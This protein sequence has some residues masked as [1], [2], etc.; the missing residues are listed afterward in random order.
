MPIFHNILSNSPPEKIKKIYSHPQAFAQCRQWLRK[1]FKEV[2]QIT[3]SSTSEAAKFASQEEGVAAIATK[4]AAEL[5]GLKILYEG[6]A[7][8]PDNTTR[9]L[10]IGKHC[11]GKSDDDKTSLLFTVKDE[12]G[13]LWEVLGVFRKYNL[14]LSKI[15]S[16]PSRTKAW[17]YVFFADVEGHID[18]EPVKAARDEVENLCASLKILGSYPRA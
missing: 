11:G 3:V 15:E 10:V 14:N 7:D 4:L 5:Y 9:F 2:E 8:K 16:R 17:E 12:V 6:I 13:A 1:S 18:D